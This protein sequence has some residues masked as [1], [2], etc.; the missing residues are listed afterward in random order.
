MYK[1]SGFEM[2]NYYVI[3]GSDRFFQIM[4][5]NGFLAGAKGR[6]ENFFWDNSVDLVSF[7]SLFSDFMDEK[8]IDPFNALHST[9][10]FID[11]A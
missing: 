1:N 4:I 3:A 10:S 6:G 8:V 2:W 11:L 7:L 9:F 5:Q